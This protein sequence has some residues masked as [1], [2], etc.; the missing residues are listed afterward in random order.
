MSDVNRSAAQTLVYELFYAIA[1]D[2]FHRVC[3]VTELTE[4]QREAL[5]ETMLRPNDFHVRVG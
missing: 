5:K 1:E 3:E 4:E 2:I